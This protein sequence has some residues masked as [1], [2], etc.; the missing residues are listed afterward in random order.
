MKLRFS[1]EY[2]PMLEGLVNTVCM[3]INARDFKSTLNI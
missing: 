3:Y 2:T 1:K